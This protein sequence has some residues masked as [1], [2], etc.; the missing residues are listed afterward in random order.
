MPVTVLSFPLLRF[1]TYVKLAFMRL[2]NQR[3]LPFSY[4]RESETSS[5]F[6]SVFGTLYLIRQDRGDERSLTLRLW[7]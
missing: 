4:P 5:D 7:E 2:Q 3:S 6:V 1:K